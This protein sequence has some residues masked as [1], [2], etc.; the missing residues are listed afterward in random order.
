[1]EKKIDRIKTFIDQLTTLIKSESNWQ[2]F[3]FAF[4][5]SSGLQF[6]Q[7]LK[8]EGTLPTIIT[9][10]TYVIHVLSDLINHRLKHKTQNNS[11]YLHE[12]VFR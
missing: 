9:E 6:L 10:N 3:C 2:R 11:G 1:M 7:K 12:S 8:V 5:M 4:L